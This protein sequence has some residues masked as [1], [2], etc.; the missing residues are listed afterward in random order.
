MDIEQ[1]RQA[2]LD[3]EPGSEQCT[4]ETNYDGYDATATAESCDGLANGPAYSCNNQK[5][6]KL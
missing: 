4:N 1:L 3:A 5:H 6:Y 2:E